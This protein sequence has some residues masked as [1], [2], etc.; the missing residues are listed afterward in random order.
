MVMEDHK[1]KKVFHKYKLYFQRTQA[2]MVH[3]QGHVEI[4][5]YNQ[6]PIQTLQV[7]SG[8]PQITSISLAYLNLDDVLN[9]GILQLLRSRIW[10]Q[11]GVYGCWGQV[12]QLIKGMFELDRV[13]RLTFKTLRPENRVSAFTELAAGLQKTKTLI[14]LDMGSGHI[15]KPGALALAQ[16]LGHCTSIQTLNID[17]LRMTGNDG[18]DGAQA[19]ACAIASNP[20]IQTLHVFCT[21]D[22]DLIQKSIL[23]KL[24]NRPCPLEELHLGRICTSWAI[25]KV[26]A[27]LEVN[28]LHRLDVSCVRN[29]EFPGSINVDVMPIIHALSI[30]TSLQVLDLSVNQI[31]DEEVMYILEILQTNSTLKALDLS[32]NRI[33]DQGLFAIATTMPRLNL[34]RLTIKGNMFGPQGT[35]QLLEAMSIES[36]IEQVDMDHHLL[37]VS[38]EI[39][40]I[41]RLNKGG[42]RV[43]LDSGFPLSL[44]PLVLE[45]VNCLEF[46]GTYHPYIGRAEILFY[47]VRYG[48]L[49]FEQKLS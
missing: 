30:N 25:S 40:W 22:A 15:S 9:R 31:T 1:T 2:K 21:S 28:K 12:D 35:S 11:L 16:G 45:R 33:S 6:D 19:L 39:A 27:L 43:L 37:P 18:I 3:P 13:E 32:Y 47:F 49:L 5:S 24:P 14:L 34:K 38:A 36:N 4:D 48:P 20:T 42:R 44:W 10:K 46:G 7:A 8:V 29:N 41:A 26:V 17:M 23:E